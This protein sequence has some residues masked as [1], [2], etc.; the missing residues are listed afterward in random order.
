[1]SATGGKVRAMRHGMMNIA[2]RNFHRD[3]KDLR[4]NGRTTRAVRREAIVRDYEAIMERIATH[5][6]E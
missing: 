2:Y 1:M 6:Q 4:P 5:P 3:G